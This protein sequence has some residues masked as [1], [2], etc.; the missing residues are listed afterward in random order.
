MEDLKAECAA[1]DQSR[2]KR[3]QPPS[4]TETRNDTP[5]QL[6]QLLATLTQNAA[7]PQ[8]HVDQSKAYSTQLIHGFETC[9]VAMVAE[10]QPTTR[11]RI[12]EKAP[13]VAEP[14]P[15]PLAALSEYKLARHNGNQP[16]ITRAKGVFSPSVATP[17]PLLGGS[18]RSN[19][20]PADLTELW[21]P[22]CG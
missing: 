19:N 10:S 15:S 8:E 4:P 12:V 7:L 14:T 13:P 9:F 3:G 6:Q 21:P 1:E 16:M 2:C 20:T 22:Q 18:L 17:A 5:G 11:R